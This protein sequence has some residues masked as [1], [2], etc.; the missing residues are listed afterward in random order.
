MNMY[1]DFREYVSGFLEDQPDYG[2]TSEDLL[3][4][5]CLVYS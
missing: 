5:M 4:R 2:R 1:E 3:N